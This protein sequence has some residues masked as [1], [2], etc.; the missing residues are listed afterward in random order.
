MRAPLA[1][2]AFRPGQFYRLQNFESLAE[3]GGDT[4]LAMEELAVTGASV[5]RDRGLLSVIVLELGGSSD[6]C[7]RRGRR[8]GGPDGADR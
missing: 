6:L 7:A 4:V 5:D 2:A 1:A 3:R 8:T